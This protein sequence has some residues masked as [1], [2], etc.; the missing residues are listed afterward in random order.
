MKKDK[1]NQEYLK[2]N[3]AQIKSLTEKLK[4][5]KEASNPQLRSSISSASEAKEIEQKLEKALI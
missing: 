2:I 1:R 4:A 5:Q 3:D